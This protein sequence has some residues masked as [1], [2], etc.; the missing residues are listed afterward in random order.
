MYKEWVDLL[1]SYV[2]QDGDALLYTKGCGSPN[3][4]FMS[5]RMGVAPL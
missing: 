4:I 2:L 1:Y 5:L 3:S